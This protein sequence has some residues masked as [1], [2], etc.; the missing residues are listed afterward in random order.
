[1]PVKAK[2]SGTTFNFA[3]ESDTITKVEG[4]G[5][6]VYTTDTIA[7]VSGNTLTFP[8]NNNLDKFEVGDVVQEDLTFFA[9]TTAVN[10]QI[11]AFTADTSYAVGL[12]N[13]GDTT[14]TWRPRTPI[15]GSQVTVVARAGNSGGSSADVVIQVGSQVSGTIV[16]GGMYNSTLSLD[17]SLLN[18]ITFEATGFD[19]N[20]GLLIESITVDGTQLIGEQYIDETFEITAIDDTV[21]SITVDGGSWYGQDGSGD[22][23]DGRFEPSQQWSSFVNGPFYTDNQTSLKMFDGDLATY[24][25]AATST[26]CIFTPPSP[27]TVNSSLRI[28]ALTYDSA[29]SYINGSIDITGLFTSDL[30]WVDVGFTGTLNTLSWQTSAGNKESLVIAAV[31]VDGNLLL[32]S[33]IPG[34][35]GATDITKTV[36][37]NTKLTVASDKDLDVITGGIYMT[38]GTVKQDGSGELEP[39]SYTPQTS[40]IA[41]VGVGPAW[42]QS[43]VWSSRVVGNPFQPSFS[44]TNM[45]SGSSDL[46]NEQT[47][48]GD[49]MTFTPGTPISGST[50]E[51]CLYAYAFGSSDGLYINGVDVTSQLSSTYPSPLNISFPLTGNSL[52]SLVMKRNSSDFGIYYMKIDG[53]ELVDAGISGDPGAGSIL[54]FNTPNPDL[55]YFEVGD[56]VQTGD[57]NQSQ[58]WSSVVSVNSQ[59]AALPLTNSFDGNTSTL[60]AASSG[61]D[62]ELNFGSLFSTNPVKLEVWSTNGAGTGFNILVDGVSKGSQVNDWVDCG[63]LTFTKIT[64]EASGNGGCINAIRVDGKLLVDASVSNPDGASITGI[65]TAANTMTVDGGDWYGADGTGKPSTPG[66]GRYM[67]DDYWALTTNGTSIENPER[68]FNGALSKT[69]TAY[70]QDNKYLQFEL[71]TVLDG[72][73]TFHV[74]GQTDRGDTVDFW[75]Y[76]EN[77]TQLKYERRGGEF[78]NNSITAVTFTDIT[79]AKTL[80]MQCISGGNG[81]VAHIAGFSHNNNLFISADVAGAPVPS[82]AT[83]I[84]GSTETAEGTFLSADGTE[85]DLSDSSGRWIADNK[86]G[87]PFSFVPSTPIVDTKNEAYGKLQIVGDKAMVTGIQADDPGFT[88]V[89]RKDYA[90]TF[91]AAFATG[92]TPDD[93]LPV[94]SSISAIVRAKNSEGESI[95]E[96]NVL[97][98]SLPNPEGSA[99]PITGATETELTVG[100]SANLDGFIANDAL[101]MVDGTG[102]VASYT[103]QTSEIASVG[104]APAW[105]QSKVWST[106]VTASTGSILSSPQGFDGDTST[107]LLSSDNNAIITLTLL[108]GLNYTSSV[109]VWL[110]T[111]DHQARIN[112]GAWVP[113]T[114]NPTEGAWTTIATGSGTIN[115]LEVQYTGGT[116]TAINAIEVDWQRLVDTGIPWRPWIR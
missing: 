51:L 14:I 55:Q 116:A 22:S 101:V 104:P 33:S 37:Y 87:I 103:P 114:G 32:D 53:M 99:G 80:Q 109:R 72:D 78:P 100:T 62:Y 47:M 54:T 75:I 63:T 93:D 69:S 52:T 60:G 105:D 49:T 67:P 1:M 48:P 88:S 70:S 16:G 102:A 38:D 96:S 79:G 20:Q 25:A 3:V 81:R 97:L 36:A 27:I 2:L 84:T 86:A 113:S 68:A 108:G 98:P 44:A 28:R 95:K 111:G 65:D 66:D 7:N 21:P 6:N 24:C 18:E 13:V 71:P 110:R 11:N 56:V 76:D 31:E 83:D 45:F 59:D 46:T 15:S 92:N 91:P 17:S 19:A 94:G 77:G 39:A 85:V 107:Y 5:E 50:I 41:S 73:F 29:P 90:I 82:G 112:N 57:W 9:P 58:E 106:N 74:K 35:Q 4:A 10:D 30:E 8:T 40:E 115:T 64:A 34:G 89:T 12:L 23:G 61:T 26:T 42:N 43:E